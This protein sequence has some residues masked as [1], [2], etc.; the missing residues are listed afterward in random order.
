MLSVDVSG[1]VAY[2]NMYPV[3][4]EVCQNPDMVCGTDSGVLFLGAQG[5]M[6]IG[7]SKCLRLSAAMDCD[8]KELETIGRSAIFGKIASL[9]GLD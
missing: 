4:H 8:G 1:T 5:V 9:Y 2:S 6:I 7:G 3:S